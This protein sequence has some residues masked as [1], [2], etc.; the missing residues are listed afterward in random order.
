MR[1][2]AHSEFSAD[3]DVLVSFAMLR[4]DQAEEERCICKIRFSC[5]AL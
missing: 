2:N 1:H 3:R 4:N 5:V